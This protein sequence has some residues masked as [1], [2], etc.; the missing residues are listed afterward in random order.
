MHYKVKTHPS[1]TTEER[2]GFAVPAA[3]HTSEKTAATALPGSKSH[4]FVT[5]VILSVHL[6]VRFL[7]QVC[8]FL[9]I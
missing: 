3:S 6:G 7:G 4:H 1:Y 5:L 8:P 2:K 9:H